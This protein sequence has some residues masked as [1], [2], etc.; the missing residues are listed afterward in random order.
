MATQK[1]IKPPYSLKSLR[2]EHFRGVQLIELDKLPEGA[3][4]IFLTGENG[5]GKTSVL[6]AIASSLAGFEAHLLKY[7][8]GEF[9]PNLSCTL[10]NGRTYRLNQQTKNIFAGQSQSQQETFPFLAC[11]GSS[12]LDTYT[13]S[14]SRAANESTTQNLYDSRALLENIE[15][16]LTRWYAKRQDPEFK[17]KFDATKELLI[18]ILQLKDII[19]DYK[20]DQVSYIEKDE[21]G[22]AYTPLPLIQ[23][24]SG[25]RSL[26]AMIG[27]MILRLFRTQPNVLDPKDLAGIVLI[28]ELDLHFHPKWQKRLPG[29][30]TKYFPKI[31]F[32]ASTHSPIPLLGAPRGSVFLTVQRS[33]ETGITLERLNHLEKELDTLTPNLLLDS[34]VFGN[35]ELFSSRFR[36]TQS[37]RTEDTQEEIAFNEQVRQ[38]LEEGLSSE[39]KAALRKLMNKG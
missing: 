5:F 21:E 28:D 31:Q 13:E 35:A 27:D 1:D 26:V 34:P 14:S 10:Y 22:N 38:S 3:P 25:Y 17:A 12:R 6:Q 32:I 39:K 2:F 19:V 18:D 20:T 8:A 9:K 4:W 15:Y 36:P 16:Q 24:A 11:Y 7:F 33:E 23:L 37:I 29:I 30:F